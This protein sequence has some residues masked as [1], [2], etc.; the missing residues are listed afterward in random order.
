MLSSVK[1]C[2]HKF[3]NVFK[4]SLHPNNLIL[5]SNRKLFLFYFPI[6]KSQLFL[7]SKSVP[8]GHSTLTK[9]SSLTLQ[10][11]QDL[12][13]LETGLC[14]HSFHVMYIIDTSVNPAA[15]VSMLYSLQQPPEPSLT[16]RLEWSLFTDTGR[17]LIELK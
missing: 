8:Y 10:G 2:I 13:P 16:S 12:K 1:P 5:F 4:I 7:F 14:S 6:N 15:H 9:K 11:Y 3:S 17:M